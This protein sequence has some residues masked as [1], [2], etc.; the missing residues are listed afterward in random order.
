MS[1]SP[2]LREFVLSLPAEVRRELCKAKCDA[3]Y[4]LTSTQGAWDVLRMSPDQVP[5]YLCAIEAPNPPVIAVVPVS[6]IAI[7]L[8]AAGLSGRDG[9]HFVSV[10]VCPCFWSGISWAEL[11]GA[12]SPR[13]KSDL[14]ETYNF[15][16]DE[17]KDPTGHRAAIALLQKVMAEKVTS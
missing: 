7:A 2:E 5:L 4:G 16:G 8:H 12:Q 6:P 9:S 13:D 14:R 3:A 10:T 1:V 17:T 15:D 11:G